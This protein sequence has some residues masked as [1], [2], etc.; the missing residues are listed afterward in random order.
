MTK[1]SKSK[2]QPKNLLELLRFESG[3]FENIRSIN[4]S[5]IAISQCLAESADEIEKL[6]KEIESLKEENQ[7]LTSENKR[8]NR[9][10]SF[11]NFKKNATL[12]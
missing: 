9:K 3:I 1:V 5:M 12:G 11:W 8:L 7:F 2:K 6:Q 10:N 4:D